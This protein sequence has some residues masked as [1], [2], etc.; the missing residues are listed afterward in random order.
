[1]NN[2]G[3]NKKKKILKNK[4]ANWKGKKGKKFRKLGKLEMLDDE[5][6]VNLTER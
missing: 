2:D 6:Y 1:M 3:K 5:F 4:I